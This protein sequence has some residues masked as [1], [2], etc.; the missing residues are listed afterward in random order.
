[1]SS[2]DVAGQLSLVDD[3]LLR[4]AQLGNEQAWNALVEIFAPVV[5][6][7]V[8]RDLDADPAQQVFRLVWMRLAERV[9]LDSESVQ[10]WLLATTQREVIRAKRLAAASA[11]FRIR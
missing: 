1:M 3:E 4:A 8:K 9:E 2:S 10:V 11:N 7:V 6:S 5:W